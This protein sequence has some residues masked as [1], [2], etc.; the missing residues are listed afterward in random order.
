MYMLAMV[1]S[2]SSVRI[3]IILW[4]LMIPRKIPKVQ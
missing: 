3:F 1:G 2:G 4:N